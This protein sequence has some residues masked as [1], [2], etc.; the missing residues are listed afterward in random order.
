MTT[1][2]Y[3]TVGLGSCRAKIRRNIAVTYHFRQQCFRNGD[4][5]FQ[6]KLISI[7]KTLENNCFAF[8]LDISIAFASKLQLN[9]QGRIARAILKFEPKF[10]FI[11]LSKI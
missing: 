3:E 2:F 10:K 5:V 7:I 6:Q 9:F 11:K 4:T 8:R 1:R